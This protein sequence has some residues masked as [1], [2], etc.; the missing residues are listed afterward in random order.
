MNDKKEIKRQIITYLCGDSDLSPKFIRLLEAGG[1]SEKDG[2]IIR[3]K[4]IEDIDSNYNFHLLFEEYYLDQLTDKNNYPA[5]EM[6][7]YTSDEEYLQLLDKHFPQSVSEA[8]DVVIGMLDSDEIKKIKKQDKSQF[9]INQHFGLGLFI[10]NHFGINLRQSM[11]LYMDI[12]EKS[13]ERFLMSDDVSGWLLGEIWEEIQKRDFDDDIT[14][15][16]LLRKCDEAYEGEDFK[17]LIEL[18]DEILDRYPNNQNAMG[19]KGISLCFLNRLDEA[20]EI[21]EKAVE[22]YPDNYYLNNNLAM[23]YYDMGEYEKSLQCC[24]A[25][26]KIRDFDWL[27]E[28]KLKALVKLERIDEAIEFDKTILHYVDLGHVFLEEDNSADAL[29]YYYGR[30]K[31]HPDDYYIIEM[32]KTVI[33]QYG[34]DTVPEVGYYY[35]EWIRDIE[36]GDSGYA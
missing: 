9:S 13:G 8:V 29:K 21:L 22:L 18:C 7:K 16:D 35:L 14:L 24:E 33:C 34:L 1:L 25:G 27:C 31:D 23:V 19:Y 15:N 36:N 30:L 11:T 17:G 32:I 10:R 26:L 5:D 4:L 12:C 3:S 20:L 2:K 28:N 6:K